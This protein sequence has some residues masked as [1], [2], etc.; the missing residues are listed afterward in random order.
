DFVA[1]LTHDIKNPLS[2]IDGFVQM[3]RENEDMPSAAREELL[4]HVQSSTRT[5]I[6]LAVNFLDTSKIEADRFVLKTRM[7]DVGDLV[8][9]VLS[10]QPPS[11]EHKGVRLV[12]DSETEL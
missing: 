7:I 10:D 3:I 2:V 5:A 9:G 4:S 11:A 1:M 12:H 6:T 8:R